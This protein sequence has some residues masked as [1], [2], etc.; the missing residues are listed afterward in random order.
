[1]WKI[2][3]FF[4]VVQINYE[5]K[6]WGISF[7]MKRHEQNEQTFQQTKQIGVCI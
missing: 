6:Y 3:F 4:G 1:M 7:A 5:K 2:L